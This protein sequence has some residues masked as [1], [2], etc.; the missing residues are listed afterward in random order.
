MVPAS[1]GTHLGDNFVL[2][3]LVDVSYTCPFDGVATEHEFE[4]SVSM[5][6]GTKMV[7]AMVLD[8]AIVMALAAMA[9][10]LIC[11]I[12]DILEAARINRSTIGMSE[13]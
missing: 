2:L 8:L 11:A 9:K 13:A 7:S 12:S 3:V 5:A 4:I 10:V 1:L 6:S